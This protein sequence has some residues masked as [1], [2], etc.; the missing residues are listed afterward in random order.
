MLVSAWS[1]REQA[2]ES[3]AAWA[4]KNS[5][6]LTKFARTM[7][8][9]ADFSISKQIYLL[10]YD[11]AIFRMFRQLKMEAGKLG[12]E[13]AL[14]NPFIIRLA[15][16][17]YLTNTTLGIMRLCDSRTKDV[18]SLSAVLKELKRFARRGIIDKSTVRCWHQNY[19]AIPL[20]DLKTYRDKY[21]ANQDI[22]HQESD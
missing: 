11:D 18:I 20:D 9:D 22:R 12:I 13:T 5:D 10:L 15:N 8:D 21:L 7:L 1:L 6:D 19:P 4:M 14:F 2:T 3:R 17:G 16:A